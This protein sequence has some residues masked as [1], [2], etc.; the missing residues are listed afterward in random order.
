MV[1]KAPTRQR[2]SQ[3]GKA[4]RVRSRASLVREVFPTTSPCPTH[5]HPQISESLPSSM[6]PFPTTSPSEDQV[7]LPAFL[8]QHP[9]FLALVH[10]TTTCSGLFSC[11]SLLHCMFHKAKDGVC[12]LHNH[13]HGPGKCSI[14]TWS[15]QCSLCNVAESGKAKVRAIHSALVTLD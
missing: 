15:S 5:K 4:H 7:P 13:T 2:G 6:R 10:N 11:L 12:L 3:L 8:L 1:L 14:S 9:P